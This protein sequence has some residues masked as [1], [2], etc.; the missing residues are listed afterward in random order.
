LSPFSPTR[1]A[2]RTKLRCV[3]RVATKA[4]GYWLTYTRDFASCGCQLEAPC[5][6][7]PGTRVFLELIDE[8]DARLG[9]A[10]HVAWC[11]NDPPFRVGVS[12]DEESTRAATLFFERLAAA[13]PELAALTPAPGADGPGRWVPLRSPL[14]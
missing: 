12:F 5:A 13:H 2:V 7:E 11:G 6:V 10:G 8:T 3:A 14:P 4:G 1:R 9:V